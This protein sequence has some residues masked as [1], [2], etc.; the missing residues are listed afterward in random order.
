MRGS[1]TYLTV[2]RRQRSDSESLFCAR[3]DPKSATR[4]LASKDANPLEMRRKAQG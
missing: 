2:A 4:A 1:V 3:R